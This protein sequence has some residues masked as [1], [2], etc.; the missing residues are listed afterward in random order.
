M[1][2]LEKS[3]VTDVTD[4]TEPGPEPERPENGLFRRFDV[5]KWTMVNESFTQEWLT[6]E[7]KALIDETK[8]LRRQ[9]EDGLYAIY[10]HAPAIDVLTFQLGMERIDE[11]CRKFEQSVMF[12]RIGARRLAQEKSATKEE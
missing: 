9:F 3:S 4:V 10:R 8:K 1:T 5:G 12:G 2:D 7:D 11:A 6:D